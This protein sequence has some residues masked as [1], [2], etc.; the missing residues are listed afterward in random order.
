MA[1]RLLLLALVA[2]SLLLTIACPIP[3]GSVS[4]I[5]PKER[6]LVA[7]PQSMRDTIQQPDL[8]VLK[9]QAFGIELPQ[10]SGSTGY[11]WDKAPTFTAGAG[12]ATFVGCDTLPV[13]DLQKNLMGGTRYE[14]WLF[15][16]DSVG[17]VAINVRYG[18]PW[19][20]T[21][22]SFTTQTFHV[23][24]LDVGVAG[25]GDDEAKSKPVLSEV[26]VDAASVAQLN[27]VTTSDHSG[28]TSTYGSSVLG[29]VAL[30]TLFSLAAIAKRKW[31]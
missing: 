22:D 19:L 9:G 20:K 28:A 3:S 27:G 14:L 13:D 12:A 5:P 16:A 4:S 6:L 1:T 15:N 2:S 29:V 11:V 8:T 21:D 7:H 10:N 23:R 17:V 31:T 24:I 18:R 25:A 26:T 30:A